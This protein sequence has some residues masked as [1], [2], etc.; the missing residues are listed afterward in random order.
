MGLR[1]NHKSAMG[2]RE[3]HRRDAIWFR[4]FFSKPHW[5]NFP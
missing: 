4:E 5:A 2:L 3:D 1:V